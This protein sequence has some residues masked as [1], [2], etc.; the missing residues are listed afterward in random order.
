MLELSGLFNLLMHVGYSDWISISRP[1]LYQWTDVELRLATGCEGVT[2]LQHQLNL[3]SAYF[4]IPVRCL[5]FTLLFYVS[6]A[7]DSTTCLGF[8]N[9]LNLMTK[10]GFAEYQ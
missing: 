7:L 8:C 4:G 5:S 3:C 1:L 6:L 10:V 2:E 9:L